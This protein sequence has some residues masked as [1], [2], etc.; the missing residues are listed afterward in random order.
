MERG[1]TSP[2]CFD[3]RERQAGFAAIN[4]TK[5]Y[6]SAAFGRAV[7]RLQWQSEETPKVLPSL[8]CGDQEGMSQNAF[9]GELTD[10]GLLR[11]SAAAK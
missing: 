11:F 4:R 3:K 8:E 7:N 6:F 2:W 1:C 9:L 5:V 10:G